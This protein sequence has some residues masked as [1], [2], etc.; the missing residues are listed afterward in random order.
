MG[1]NI[2]IDTREFSSAMREYKV[3]SRRNMATILNTKA[4]YISRGAVRE[5]QKASRSKIKQELQQMLRPEGGGLGA[6]FEKAYPQI[7]KEHSISRKVTVNG[8]EVPLVAL[9]VNFRRGRKG[10]KGLYGQAM[11]KASLSFIGFAVRSAGAIAAG[12]IPSA[13]GF[14][15]L[16]EK[17]S[18]APPE[19]KNAVQYGKPKGSFKVALK[20]TERPFAEIINTASFKGDHKNALKRYGGE[21]LRRAFEKEVASMRQYVLE[22]ANAAAKQI[23]PK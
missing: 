20:N 8:K 12:F 14:E 11:A 4:F 2:H 13:K 10:E 23:S 19:D 7:A 5:T 22:K 1:A 18:K 15:P 3:M 21:G 6:F 16:A 17:K 9:L